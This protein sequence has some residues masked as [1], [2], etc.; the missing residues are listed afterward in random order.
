M[1]QSLKSAL[2]RST[3]FVARYGGE[4]FVAVLPETNI[5]FAS[6]LA[7]KMR[8]NVENL[9]I[10][11]AHSRASG[12]VTICLGVAATIPSSSATF[13]DLIKTADSA[14][15]KAKESG[16]NRVERATIK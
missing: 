6:R 3:D 7:E 9:K 16:R 5:E 4:E 8:F 14:L 10:P 15:Y 2:A 1:A 12:K 13:S 11:H